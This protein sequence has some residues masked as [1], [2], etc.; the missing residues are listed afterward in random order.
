MANKKATAVDVYLV[1]SSPPPQAST[2]FH[3]LVLV[4]RGKLLSL[5]H[6]KGK[7]KGCAFT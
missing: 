1:K 7:S 5:V 2:I 6:L 3:D 4:F